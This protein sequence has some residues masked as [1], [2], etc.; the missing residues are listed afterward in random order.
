MLLVSQKLKSQTIVHLMAHGLDKVECLQ[1][2]IIGVFSLVL[3]FFRAS[4][5]DSN[6]NRQK[7]RRLARKSSEA[8]DFAE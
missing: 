7:I 3:M 6:K 2:L 1:V 4:L 8:N 5:C